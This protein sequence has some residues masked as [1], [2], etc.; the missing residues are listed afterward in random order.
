MTKDNKTSPQTE[1]SP[2]INTNTKLCAYCGQNKPLSHFIRRTGKRSNRGSRRGACRSC[3]QL[4]KE[5]R[6]ITSSATNTEINPS[7]DTTFQPKRL[8]KRTLPVPPPRVDGLDLVILKPN[9]HGL[10]RMRGRTDNGRRWQQE[11]DFNLAVIL[12]KEHAAVVVNR[13]TIR[14]IYSNKSFRRYILERDK[15]TCFF[16]GEYG[17]TI[18]HLLPRAKGGHTTPA[19]CVCA[20]NLCNQNKAARSLEDF[21]EDSSEL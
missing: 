12:V 4:K 6:A 1:I 3:R 7:T 16:C 11:V 14:R 21:M 13:H 2:E 15:H 5:Q 19:N 8:I 10:V 18:D 20:C 9:R 17:D